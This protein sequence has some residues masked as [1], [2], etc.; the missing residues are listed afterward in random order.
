M[1]ANTLFLEAS[2]TSFFVL[3]VRR[4]K[5]RH[6]KSSFPAT[7]F[8]Q[9][10]EMNSSEDFFSNLFGFEE[11]EYK[12]TQR[13]FLEIASFREEPS[14]HAPY[15]RER[16]ELKISHGK[17]ITAGIFAMPSLAELREHADRHSNEIGQC[18][19][20]T[21]EVQ[22]IVGESRSLHSS[23]AV[24]QKNG[25]PVVIQAASQFN[26]LEFPSPYHIPEDGI[27]DY[28][29]DHTQGPACATACAAGTAYRNYA[30][31]VPFRKLHE[32]DEHKNRGQ[33]KLHQLNGLSDVE[34]FFLVKDTGLGES[35]WVVKNGYIESTRKKLEP[36]NNLLSDPKSNL[37]E[38]MISLIRIGLQQD[39]TVTDDVSMK[40]KVTQTY[41]SAISIGYSNLP[42][43]LW[44]S[45]AQLV[46]EAT[47]EATLLAGI[48]QSRS[49][50]SPTII[51]LT[52]V[53]GGVFQNRDDWILKAMIS[54]I[55]KVRKYKIPLDVRIVHYGSI[56][57][58]YREVE[59]FA[60]NK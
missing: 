53:G 28:I 12:E 37:R 41:N 46:L 26:F 60:V 57:N 2:I 22:N 51:F 25:A 32:K 16:C 15:F 21:I 52:K 43:N 45:V 36:L 20:S 49:R 11:R 9:N 50:A 38:D 13:N 7:Y 6:L 3:P 34:E 33:T 14:D 17:T 54:A 44:E 19:G 58:V 40:S 4:N 29:H 10:T 31:P 35:P 27:S 59:S 56:A 8:C 23:D 18:E 47:Y 39:T 30:V 55:R 24:K 5:K 42:E 1:L 48:I